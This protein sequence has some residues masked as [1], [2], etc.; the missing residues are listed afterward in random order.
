VA[1]FSLTIQ[2]IPWPHSSLLSSTMSELANRPSRFLPR[3]PY[4]FFFS[5]SLLI[6]A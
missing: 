6:F 3:S 1:S 4:C 2:P 5:F